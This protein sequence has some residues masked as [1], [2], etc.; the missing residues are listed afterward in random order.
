MDVEEGKDG[1]REGSNGSE[2][3]N[4]EFA[5][6]LSPLTSSGSSLGSKAI[7]FGVY[8][9]NLSQLRKTFRV[10]SQPS[11]KSAP[12]MVLET[13]GTAGCILWATVCLVPFLPACWA[14]AYCPRS[15]QHHRFVSLRLGKQH[16]LRSV[17]TQ[18]CRDLSQSVSSTTPWTPG[19]RGRDSSYLYH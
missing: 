19:V 17:M 18:D 2:P 12:S 16:G 9:K 11:M 15:V 7:G 6:S 10:I 4:L 1:P 13:E 14:T 8:K 3:Y 5:L